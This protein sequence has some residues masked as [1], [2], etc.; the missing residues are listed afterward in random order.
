MGA[1]QSRGICM[2][3]IRNKR[4]MF[5]TFIAITIMTV[6]LLLFTPRADVSLQVDAERTSTRINSI[7]N[8]IDDLENQYFNTVLRS[9]THKAILSLIFYINETDSFL[10]DLDAAFQEVIINGTINDL[11]IDSVTNKKIMEGSTLTNWSDKIIKTA[12]ETLNV[13]TSILINNVSLFQT[14]PWNLESTV[15]LNISVSSAV[16]SWNVNSIITASIS[17]E[18]LHDPYYLINTGGVYTNRIKRSSIELNLWNISQVREH[19]RN[20]TYVHRQ[21]A[22]APSFLMRFT[23]TIINSSCCGIESIVN[24]N[25][26]S[27][28]DQIDSYVDYILWNPSSNIPCNELNNITNPSTGGGLWDEF[29]YFKLDLNHTVGYNIT[30][31]DAVR[32][33]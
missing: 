25:K 7:N 16:A 26:I 20:G 1:I 21:N 27:S 29:R 10:S 33:C 32:T 9:S 2:G 6:F 8:F 15:D 24:P 28:S 14:T 13:N 23:N 31:Q 12:Q 3:K 22:P 4:G 30:D 11:P 5:F 18:G 19:L 17:I